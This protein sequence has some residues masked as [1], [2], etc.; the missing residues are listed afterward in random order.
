MR[1]RVHR[2]EAWGGAFVTLGVVAAVVMLWDMV[3]LFSSGQVLLGDVGSGSRTLCEGT[4]ILVE[5]PYPGAGIASPECAFQCALLSKYF[6]V[7]ADID[8]E[9]GNLHAFRCGKDAS[10][11]AGSRCDAAQGGL[12]GACDSGLADGGTP[13]AVEVLY[14]GNVVPASSSRASSSRDALTTWHPAPET[15]SSASSMQASAA[16][17]EGS[18]ILPMPV[19]SPPSSA[20]SAQVP[21]WQLQFPSP[22]SSSVPSMEGRCGDGTR[23]A[24]EECDEGVRNA[25]PGSFCT[26]E[27]R[28]VAGCGDGVVEEGEACD[29]GP[30]NGTKGS[31]CTELCL[32]ERG[33][34]PRCGDGS[35]GTG[36]ECDAG[37]Q[38]GVPGGVCDIHCRT[39]AP[40]P[41]AWTASVLPSVAYPLAAQTGPAALLVMA[42]GAAVGWLWFKR[43]QK[44]K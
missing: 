41:A 38:N 24:R 28:R 22:S 10:I 11:R 8:G 40:H 39:V 21:S 14:R 27:C 2:N 23:D 6:V 26:A 12:D 30:R 1:R 9:T 25:I 16:S 34:L 18:V 32:V 15:G 43:K 20:S 13:V 17:S 42:S 33:I 3:S 4:P 31:P 7:Y 29:D 37:A 19:S 36:E 35:L 5:Y 44:R